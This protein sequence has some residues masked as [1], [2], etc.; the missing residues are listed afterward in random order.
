MLNMYFS[1]AHYYFNRS[2]ATQGFAGVG[3]FIN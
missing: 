2:F 1:S 3:V